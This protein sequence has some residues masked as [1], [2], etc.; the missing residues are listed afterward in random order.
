VRKAVALAAGG[1]LAVA[2]AIA[3]ADI[4]ARY[5]GPFPS[6]LLSTSI[7]G[8][9]TGKTLM[10]KYTFRAGLRFIPT[11]ANYTC[12]DARP[13]RTDCTGRFET[14]EGQRAGPSSVQITWKAG[15]PVKLH[16]GKKM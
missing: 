6:T 14:D 4:P 9:F 15:Q 1:T 2:A 16:F 13:N 3:A 11:T 7:T 5:V 12:I 10:L 8:V